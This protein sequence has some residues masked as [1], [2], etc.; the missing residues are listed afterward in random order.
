[1][2]FVETTDASFA[3]VV[4]ASDIPVIAHFTAPGC[5]PCKAIEPHLTGIA[6]DHEGRVRLA[7]IDIDANLDTPG[8]YGVLSIPTVILFADGAPRETLVGAHPRRRY[9]DAFAPYLPR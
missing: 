8:R 2:A 3:D 9:D 4:L 6:K 7:R 5:R 1:M